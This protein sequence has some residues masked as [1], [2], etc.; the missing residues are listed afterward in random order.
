MSVTGVT[1][2]MNDVAARSHDALADDRAPQSG[3][4]KHCPN[5][6]ISKPPWYSPEPLNSFTNA[7]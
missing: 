2:S 5:G 4:L 6:P 3:G 1:L 7:K